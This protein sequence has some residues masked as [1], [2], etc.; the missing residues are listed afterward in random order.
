VSLPHSPCCFGL[1]AAELHDEFQGDS[2]VGV[3]QESNGCKAYALELWAESRERIADE[4]RD[5]AD[6]LARL[7]F[8]KEAARDRYVSLRLRARA[9]TERVEA[10]NL[11]RWSNLEGYASPATSTELVQMNAST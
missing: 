9:G 8:M 4:L 1:I 5:R 10:A 11:W 2:R 7:G 3:E 6:C